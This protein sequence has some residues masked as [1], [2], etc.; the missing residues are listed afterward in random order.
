MKM[1]REL[2]ERC[3]L[4]RACVLRGVDVEVWVDHF[5]MSLPGSVTCCECEDC[6]RGVCE[7]H[8]VPVVCMQNNLYDHMERVHGW[9]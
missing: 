3:E 4:E 5:G 8:G 9:A 7:G 6:R 2:D 1:R